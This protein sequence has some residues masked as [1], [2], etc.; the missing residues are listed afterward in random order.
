MSNNALAVVRKFFPK[1]AKVKD[2]KESI[3]VEVTKQDQNAAKRLKHSECAMAVACRRSL[4]LDGVIIAMGT[5]Y[6]IKDN[7]ATRYLTTESVK[8]EITSFDRSGLFA[9]GSYMLHKPHPSKEL[10]NDHRPDKSNKR[11]GK[12]NAPMHFTQDVRVSL[13]K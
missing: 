9:P 1:V 5:T 13:Q 4:K 7:V 11:S 8:R 6:T 10:G 3:S 2:A 12:R